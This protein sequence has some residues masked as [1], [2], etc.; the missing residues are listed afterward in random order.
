MKLLKVSDETHAR[1]MRLSTLYERPMSRL[2]ELYAEA[3]E[4]AWRRRMTSDQRA[5]SSVWYVWAC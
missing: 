5:R 1:L 4:D 2:V 3:S